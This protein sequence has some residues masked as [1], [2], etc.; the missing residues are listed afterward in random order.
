MDRHQRVAVAKRVAAARIALGIKTKK[1]AARR[2]GV[3]YRQYRA[4]EAGEHIPQDETLNKVMDAFKMPPL[5]EDSTG[6]RIWLEHH[7]NGSVPRMLA[8]FVE[9]VA[10]AWSAYLS[11]LASLPEP[12]QVAAIKEIVGQGIAPGDRHA[13][14]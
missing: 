14:G 12:E 3:S 7:I 10:D 2:A 13:V 8:L 9:L 4:I 6:R 1:E 11:D 5:V